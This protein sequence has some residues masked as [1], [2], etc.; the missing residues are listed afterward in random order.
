VLRNA[1]VVLLAIVPA[2]ASA[3]VRMDRRRLVAVALPDGLYITNHDVTV[4]LPALRVGYQLHDHLMLEVGASYLPP[5]N[6]LA[7]VGGR[8]LFGT[9]RVAPY[10]FARLGAYRD[11]PDEG[12]DGT[13][14]FALGGAGIDLALRGGFAAWAEGGL[15]LAS[16]ENYDV[17]STELAAYVSAGLGYRF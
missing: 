7:H 4:P 13:Y 14:P 17:R 12:D 9:A 2:S 8:Y 15:G 1:L 11:D 3:D 5:S 16:Y 6:A 10:A